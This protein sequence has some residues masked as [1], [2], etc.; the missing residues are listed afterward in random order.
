MSDPLT[1]ITA[2]VS[3]KLSL[4][5]RRVVKSYTIGKRHVPVLQGVDLE[6]V[7]GEFVAILGASGAGKSTLLHLFAGLDTPDSGSI[8]VEGRNLSEDKS[9]DLA[10][11]RRTRIG[12]PFQAYHL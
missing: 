7:Q 4:E 1:G 9:A 11:F 3:A 2:S 12:L 10:R 8:V 6:V 5:A